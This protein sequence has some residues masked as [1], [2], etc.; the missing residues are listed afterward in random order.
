MVRAI[1]YRTHAI[2]EMRDTLKQLLHALT[3]EIRNRRTASLRSPTGWLNMPS[4]TKVDFRH[5]G[6]KRSL[7]AD[8]LTS[9][10]KAQLR[11]ECKKPQTKKPSP[12]VILEASRLAVEKGH[13][14][15]LEHVQRFGDERDQSAAHLLRANQNI[16][17]DEEWA[18][19]VNYYLEQFDLEPISVLPGDAPRYFRITTPISKKVL[20]GP[21]VTILVP[22]FNAAN[23]IDFSV[24]SLLNQ[25][26]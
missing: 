3:N 12:N 9:A 11:A 20:D 24:G 13:A 2:R 19:H 4:G 17:S 26:W 10:K 16:D 18:K 8:Q 23:F 14:A 22:A 21:L 25:T 7:A 1:E 5:K 15:A 6:G